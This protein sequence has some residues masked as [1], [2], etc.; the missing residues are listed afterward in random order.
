MYKGRT[1]PHFFLKKTKQKLKNWG[2][3][4]GTGIAG[5]GQTGDKAFWPGWPG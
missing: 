3:A 2:E 5:A 4:E 1:S